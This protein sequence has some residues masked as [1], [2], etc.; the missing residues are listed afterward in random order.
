[1]VT[2]A[3]AALAGK[4]MTQ[5]IRMLKATPQRTAEMRRLAP[6]PEWTN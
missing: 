2:Q 6:A 1:M 5:A 3:T 4:V